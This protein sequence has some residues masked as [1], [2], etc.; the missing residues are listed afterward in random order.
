MLLLLLHSVL[1]QPVE[2]RPIMVAVWLLAAVCNIVAAA[3]NIIVNNSLS[4][5][6]A[7][8]FILFF[9]KV[10]VVVCSVCE[11]VA[12][13]ILY[14]T[15]LYFTFL[16]FTLSVSVRIITVS[17]EFPSQFSPGTASAT[18]FANHKLGLLGA[19]L[20]RRSNNGSRL[21]TK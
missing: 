2:Q 12:L 18:G 11:G 15:F 19:S 10:Y 17:P 3:F 20:F 13:Y 21:L 4:V 8:L 6:L 7:Q 9:R 16:Y 5:V 14:F 1:R